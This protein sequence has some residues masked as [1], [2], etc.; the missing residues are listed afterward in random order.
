MI[1]WTDSMRAELMNLFH[2]AHTALAEGG[3]SRYERKL[4]AIRKYNE[5]HPEVS[6][7]AAYKELCREE[8]WRYVL[9][10][11][12]EPAP[13]PKRFKDRCLVCDGTRRVYN[14]NGRKMEPCPYCKGT[15]LQKNRV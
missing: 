2:L 4:W 11:D 7:T 12:P 5:A 10:P 1:T 13:A 15:G 8:E 14:P 9:T 6:T 3:P